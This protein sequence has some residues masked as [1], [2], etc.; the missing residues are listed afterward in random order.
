[1]QTTTGLVRFR[2]RGLGADAALL[3]IVGEREV[4]HYQVNGS[5]FVRGGI[6][7]VFT[8]GSHGC[9]KVSSRTSDLMNNKFRTFVFETFNEYIFFENYPKA[10]SK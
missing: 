9:G 6:L 5:R 3:K 1:M 4:F 8:Y 10:K 2:S 7:V